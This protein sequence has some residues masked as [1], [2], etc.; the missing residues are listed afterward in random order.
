MR[1]LIKSKSKEFLWESGAA[2]RND[3]ATEKEI[4]ILKPLET[5]GLSPLPILT[6]VVR[7]ITL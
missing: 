7:A 3:I 6:L 1:R 5:R 2:I 4:M